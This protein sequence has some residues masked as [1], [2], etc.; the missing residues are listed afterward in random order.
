LRSAWGGIGLTGSCL[1][2]NA[3]T[4]TKF[5]SYDELVGWLITSPAG[6][7][8]FSLGLPPFGMSRTEDRAEGCRVSSTRQHCRR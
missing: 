2:Y 4:L 1:Y 8:T 3:T 5:I 6:R 7:L